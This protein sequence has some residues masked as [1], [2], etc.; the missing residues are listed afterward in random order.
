MLRFATLRSFSD[1]ERSFR[2]GL[3]EQCHGVTVIY[4]SFVYWCLDEWSGA[5][6]ALVLC[7]GVLLGVRYGASSTAR[8]CNGAFVCVMHVCWAGRWWG[9]SCCCT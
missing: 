4:S 2:D 5:L 8:L 7:T 1:D 9:A 3:Y 6:S